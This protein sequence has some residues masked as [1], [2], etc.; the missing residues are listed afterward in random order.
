MVGIGPV[1]SLETCKFVVA[2]VASMMI[3]FLMG[4]VVASVAADAVAFI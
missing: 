1:G 2:A 3:A 4:V